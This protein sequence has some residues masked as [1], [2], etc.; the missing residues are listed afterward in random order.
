MHGI[1]LGRGRA[2]GRPHSSKNCKTASPNFRQVKLLHRQFNP[3]MLL[4]NISKGETMLDTY[5]ELRERGTSVRT[6]VVAG[7]T[8]F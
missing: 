6:E 1:R 5:F 2:A 8:T 4:Q 7:V 3:K